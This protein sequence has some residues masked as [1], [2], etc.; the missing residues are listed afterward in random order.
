MEN[1]LTIVVSLAGLLVAMLTAITS[2][3]RSEARRVLAWCFLVTATLIIPSVLLIW[4]AMEVSARILAP[5]ANEVS[6]F[7]SQVSW[8]VGVSGALYPLIWGVRFYPRL[9]GYVSKLAPSF[10]HRENDEPFE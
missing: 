6:T 10:D 2:E 7:V 4:A 3:R 5:T 1:Y 8:S 9:E